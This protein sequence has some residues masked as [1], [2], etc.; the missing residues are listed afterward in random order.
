M[1]TFFA[2][3]QRIKVCQPPSSTFPPKFSLRDRYFVRNSIIQL[4]TLDTTVARILTEIKEEN[5]M[6]PVVLAT[7][8]DL[9][10]FAHGLDAKAVSN[11]NQLGRGHGRH[12]ETAA[13]LILRLFQICASDSRTQMDDSKKLGMM[14]LANQLFKI[15]FQINKLNLCKPMIR[16][17]ENMNI[18]DR[19]SLAQRVTYS[20]YVGRKAMFDGDFVSADKSLSFAFERCLGSA[21]HNKRLILIYLIPVKMLLGVFPYPSLLVKY[22]LNEFLGISDAAKYDRSVSSPLLSHCRAGNLQKM[23]MELNKYEEFFLS[24]GVYLIL[25]KLKLITYR[26]LFKKVC[27]IMKTHL[28]PIEVF[29]AALRLMGVFAI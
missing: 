17:I 4:I 29:T 2:I 19:F 6:L 27:A 3:L 14:G 12:M 15:Y 5:W 21:W 10:R 1:N 13:Q 8:I 28:M 22:N 24:C 25:E 9:R 18:N 23:D 7:A 11:T 16:A 20:Y 26:N